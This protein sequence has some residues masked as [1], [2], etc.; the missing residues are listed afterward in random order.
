MDS[1]VIKVRAEVRDRLAIL[2]A[3]RGTTIGSM[4][5]ELATATP[6][7][8]ERQE[9]YAHNMA[10]IR[11]HLQPELTDEDVAEAEALWQAVAAGEAGEV[12]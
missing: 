7:H 4:V 1:A 11:E 9:M 3:D 2:A 10:Y 8:A 12:L 6:T 5:A